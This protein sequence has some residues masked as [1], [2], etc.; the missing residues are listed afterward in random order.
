MVHTISSSIISEI[1]NC[2]SPLEYTIFSP[3]F[4]IYL[5]RYAI[6]SPSIALLSISSKS[7][8]PNLSLKYVSA[9]QKQANVIREPLMKLNSIATR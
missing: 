3:V 8:L 7:D 2:G 5:V 1:K 9:F 6:D 4:S